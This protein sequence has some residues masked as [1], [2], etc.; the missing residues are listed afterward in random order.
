MSVP[1]TP[2]FHPAKRRTGF[3]FYLPRH[4]RILSLYGRFPGKYKFIDLWATWCAPCKAEIPYLQQLEAEFQG[5]E[6][7]F[8]S[9]SIDKN[10]KKWKDYV[11]KHQLGGVQLW[12]GDWSYLPE[13]LHVG[14]IPR[15][16]LI[17]KEGNWVDTEAFRPSNPALKK[18][19]KN[20]L[21]K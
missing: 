7:E 14:S 1:G 21:K 18:L 4:C 20:L 11:R 10:R 9:I 6:I 12:A 5:K 19:L 3:E 13:E 16:I 15:F 17:D 8:I 2:S